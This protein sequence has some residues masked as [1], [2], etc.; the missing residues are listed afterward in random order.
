MAQKAYILM[1]GIWTIRFFWSRSLSLITLLGHLISDL[2]GYSRH[3]NVGSRPVLDIWD[4]VK[5]HV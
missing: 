4:Q 2:K 1:Q 5:A 3:P